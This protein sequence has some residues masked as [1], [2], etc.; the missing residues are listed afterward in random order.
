MQKA[1]FISSYEHNEQIPQYLTFQ[2]HK[3]HDYLD[4]IVK[5]NQSIYHDIVV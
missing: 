5:K 3:P 2:I 1:N 4:F